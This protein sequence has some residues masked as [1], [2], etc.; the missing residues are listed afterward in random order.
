[1]ILWPSGGYVL[2]GGDDIPRTTPLPWWFRRYL[3]T[4]EATETAFALWRRARG[5]IERCGRAISRD[6]GQ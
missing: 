2:R 6:A 3:N 4:G 1:M 5:V